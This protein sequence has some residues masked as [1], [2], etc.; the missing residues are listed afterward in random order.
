MNPIKFFHLPAM[1]LLVS[2]APLFAVKAQTTANFN[3]RPP[4]SL[5]EATPAPPNLPLNPP[6]M[7]GPKPAVVPVTGGL[8]VNTDEREEVR[9]FYNGIFPVSENVPQDSTA[10]GPGCFPGHNSDAFQ[11]AELLRLNWYRAMAGDPANIVLNP[12]D[13]WGSQQMA[14]II[15][16]NNALNHNPPA[17]YSC[18]NTF[19]ASYAGG[20]Q[21]LGAD[22]AEATTDFIWDFGANNNEVGHRRWILYPEE[23]VMGVGDVPDSGTNAAANLTYVFDP[24]S[25][26]ARPATRQPYVAWPP[27]GYAPYQV[28]FPYWSFA[29]SNA[30]FTG[31]TVNMT[32]NGVP[33]STVI[34]PYKI[35]YG[36]NTLVWVPMGLDATTEGTSF[37]FN[38][39]DTVYSVTVGNITNNGTTVQYSYNVTVFDPAVPGSDYVPTTLIGPIQAPTNATTLY[40]AVAPA[41]PNVTSYNFQTAQLVPASLTDDA[42]NGLTNFIATVGTDYSVITSWPFGNGNCF[43]LEHYAADSYPQ[44]LQFAETLI[45]A[46]NASLSFESGLGYATPDEVARVQV[47]ADGGLNWTDLFA[48]PGNDSPDGSFTTESLSLS[49]YA[50]MTILLRFNFDFQGGSYYNS[51]YPIGWFFT[52]IV[53][54]NVQALA[55]QTVYS[56]TTNIVSGNLVDSANNGLTNFTLTPPP[57]YYL[58]T[59]PPVGTEANCFHLCHQDSTSQYL[60]F[61]EVFLPNA[62]SSI[63][64]SSQLGDATSD[65]N[66]YL[67]VSTNNGATWDQWFVDSGGDNTPENSFTPYTFSLAAYAGQLTWIRFNFSFTGGSYYPQSQNYIGWNIEDIVVTNIQQQIITPLMSTNFAFTPT[68]PGQY[69]LQAEPVIFSQFPLSYGPVKQVTVTANISPTLVLNSPILTNQQVLLNFT[70]AN[71]VN[72]TYHLQQT[73]QLINPAWATNTAAILITNVLNQSYQF[74]VTNSS[75]QEFYRV[76][77]P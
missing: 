59:N 13:D 60:Q 38:G 18:Y 75:S 21:S 19:A 48:Q 44:L 53:L 70:V 20:D 42:N 31:A 39:T 11:A 37:P 10:D 45:P 28:V 4:T 73:A 63:S 35:G 67:E 54:T 12:I 68:Q 27:E 29:L 61:N 2:L 24:A 1:L 34:Q 40:S 49:N 14:V 50:G 47:S 36:E 9:S 56:G 15:N 17:S 32:S 64:F 51:G 72:S 52:D 41:D 65:E 22:G 5:G 3:P 58:I 69:L 76:R 57:Y 23:T 74:E 77:T 46:T 66:A 8:V 71:P 7:I 30:D 25:F 16:A 55:N 33:V 62:A 43:N 26:G 6:P